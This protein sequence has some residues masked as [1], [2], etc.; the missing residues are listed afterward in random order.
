[1][2]S[3]DTQDF[4][5]GPWASLR[6]PAGWHD[7]HEGLLRLLR[8]LLEGGKA[9]DDFP[10]APGLLPPSTASRARQ[11]G[12]NLLCATAVSFNCYTDPLKQFTIQMTKLKLSE[13]KGHL[14]I[15]TV[16]EPEL[17]LFPYL[18]GASHSRALPPKDSSWPSSPSSSSPPKGNSSKLP[19]LFLLIFSTY[20]LNSPIMPGTA[21]MT[22]DTWW[23]RQMQ[24]LPWWNLI[25]V[26]RDRLKKKNPSKPLNEEN[27]FR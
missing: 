21:P 13:I 22:K 10:G 16:A 7:L 26:R 20:L 18:H 2:F 11:S 12:T 4:T 17:W 25:L 5:T 15:R 1:M 24:S 8:W 3:E 9:L 23:T 6:G 27:N 19:T 14:P